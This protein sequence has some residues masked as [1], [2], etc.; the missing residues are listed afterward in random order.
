MLGGSERF[1]GPAPERRKKGN[2]GDWPRSQAMGQ[3]SRRAGVATRHAQGRPEAA[4]S[5]G[6]E[7]R[8][9][10]VIVGAGLSGLM[11]ARTLC[12]AGAEPLV[13][14]ARGR[15]GGRTWT[16]PASDGT[17]LDLG[18]QW[19][20]PTQ[21][22]ILALAEELGVQTFKTYDTGKNIEYHRGECITYSG[23]IP[24]HDPVTSADAVEALLT[25]N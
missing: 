12:A 10:V 4:T 11:V 21:R 16:R 20:G 5:G 13:L 17:P 2:R 6:G 24:T 23:A 14:E 9:E 15:V 1:L 8:A 7:R 3:L 22:R 18:G 19:I 25:L